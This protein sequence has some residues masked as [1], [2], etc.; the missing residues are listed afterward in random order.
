MSA[1]ALAALTLVVLLAAGCESTGQGASHVLGAIGAATGLPGFSSAATMAQTDVRGAFVDMDEPE[2]VELGRAIAAAVGAR[3]PVLRDPA[4]TRY[5]ALVGNTVAAVSDRPD[6]R[7]Y[8]AVLDSPDINALAAP[9]GFVFVTTG[10][11]AA[12]KDEAAL[13]GVLGHEVG[14]IALRHHGET[15]KAQKR[16]TLFRAVGQE[17]LSY[18]PGVGAFSGLIGL[19]ADAIAEQVILKGHSRAEE[20]ESDRV[21]FQYAARAGYDPAGLREFLATLASRDDTGARKFFS[22]H[23]GT[24]ERLQEQAKLRKEWTGG[25]RREA[26]RFIAAMG[27]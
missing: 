26:A 23:P 21:G 16:K 12:M 15:I 1:R 18:A 8:F 7:Y 17:A 14:H 10:A 11:L 2:E 6:L 24:D 3:Y 27:R 22:T 4:L 25:G 5:V 19:T 20:M 13:A 9:G